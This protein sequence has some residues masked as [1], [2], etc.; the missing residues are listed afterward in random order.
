MGVQWRCYNSNSYEN[1]LRECNFKVQFSLVAET[2]Y[3]R[4]AGW[5]KWQRNELAAMHIVCQT[6]RRLARSVG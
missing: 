4:S 6:R 2:L 1:I 3:A 5:P